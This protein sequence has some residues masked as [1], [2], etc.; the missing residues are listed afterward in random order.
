MSGK[1]RRPGGRWRLL[2]HEYL[3]RVPGQREGVAGLAHHVVPDAKGTPDSEFSRTHVL[4]G[5]EFDELVVGRWLH[6][7]QMDTGVWWMNIGGV[8][9]HVTADRDG[10]P[11]R[12]WVCGP[13][14][15]DA[16]RPGCAYELSWSDPE[17]YAKEGER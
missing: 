11:K 7:E 14:D 1:L 12:V 4:P 13:E 3:G 16:P 17:Q 6:V 8:T 2:V 10:R 5:T 9:V 15:Y